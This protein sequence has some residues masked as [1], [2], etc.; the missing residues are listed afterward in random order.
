MDGVNWTNAQGKTLQLFHIVDA[1]SNFHVAIATP[2]KTN[3]IINILNQHWMS[4]A[5]PPT[6]LQVDSGT[7][8][9]SEEF[10]RFLQRFGI[11]GNT[12][13]P[14]AHWQTGKVER[15]GKF[16]QHMLTKLDKEFPI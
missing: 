13:C 12:T 4:W 5:G 14:L 7:E 16:L 6:E 15:H 9:N 8:L 3:D 11:K 2:A 10:A 1:G